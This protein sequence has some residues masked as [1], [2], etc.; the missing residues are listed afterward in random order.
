[1]PRSTVMSTNTSL[2]DAHW[3]DKVSHDQHQA[4]EDENGEDPEADRNQLTHVD[5]AGVGPSPQS[6]DVSAKALVEHDRDV[7]A[8]Q[9]Q[10]GKQVEQ[11]H[12]YVQR[13]D[14]QN[15]EGDLL[16]PA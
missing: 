9:R 8:V 1:M 7:P 12:K 3:V 16:L 13:G 14:D 2:D 4:D 6:G 10:Q 15:S 11:P 5:Q